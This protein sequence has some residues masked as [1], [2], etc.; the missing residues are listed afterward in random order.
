MISAKRWN[1]LSEKQSSKLVAEG[2]LIKMPA[3][4]RLRNAPP[5]PALPWSSLPR[6][7]VVLIS[8]G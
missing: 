5:G 6:S 2:L 7:N 3:D 8:R 1:I 4:E